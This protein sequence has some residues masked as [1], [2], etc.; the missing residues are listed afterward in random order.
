MV[1]ALLALL[2][3]AP[4]DVGVMLNDAEVESRDMVSTGE[5]FRAAVTPLAVWLT[6]LSDRQVLSTTPVSADRVELVGPG[7]DPVLVSVPSRPVSPVR[8]SARHTFWVA[9]GLDT[10]ALVSPDI[11]IWNTG[12]PLSPVRAPAARLTAISLLV[13]STVLV[14]FRA[15]PNP[16]PVFTLAVT[17]APDR[18]LTVLPAPPL[19]RA[20]TVVRPDSSMLAT[21]I[22]GVKV[23]V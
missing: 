13:E 1:M 8:V 11:W 21:D 18:P 22:D 20:T 16:L 12:V 5:T 7:L 3:T 15:E 19:G 4:V 6:M 17:V 2:A 10:V 14:R 9:G 23:S